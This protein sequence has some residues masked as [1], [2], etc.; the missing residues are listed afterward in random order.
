MAAK[1]KLTSMSR[2]MIFLGFVKKEIMGL[3]ILISSDMRADS[4][5]IP[6]SEIFI[7]RTLNWQLFQIEPEVRVKKIKIFSRIYYITKDFQLYRFTLE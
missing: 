7:Q 2:S 5:G 1:D 6:V 4:R 3:A